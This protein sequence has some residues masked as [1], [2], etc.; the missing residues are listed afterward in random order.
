MSVVW[1]RP[2]WL[3][4]LPLL[5]HLAVWKL[6]RAGSALSFPRGAS[7]AHEGV[8]VRWALEK[9]PVLLRIACLFLLVLALARPRTVASVAEEPAAGVPIVV[10]IDVSSSMLA[11]DFRP[12]DRLEVAKR[13]VASFV[14]GRPDDPV[15]LVA[16]AAEALTLVPLT[17]LQPVLLSALGSLRVG[18]LEDGTA[19]GEGLATAVNRLR[20]VEAEDRVV[21]LMSDG[22][23]NR[24]EVDPMEAA[25]AAATYGIRVFAIGVGSEG[26]A[27]VPVQEEGGIRYAEL[28][29]GI[30]EELLRGIAET[31]GGRYFRATDPEALRRIYDRIDGLVGASPEP[32]RLV[33]YAEWYLPLLLAAAGALL[34]EW[35]LRGSRWGTVP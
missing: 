12:D 27:P 19:I 20:G 15:G 8:A 22:E 25:R 23:S 6:R 16:F 4:L 28:P 33:E 10:A 29:V 18:L 17:T 13:T 7:L 32:T 26:V 14:R 31:T 34:G 5:L 21:I 30:D 35:L 3:L 9:A 2:E 1:A 24:G 11:Q